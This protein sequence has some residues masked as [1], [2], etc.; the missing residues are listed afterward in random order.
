MKDQ[1]TFSDHTNADAITGAPGS[2]PGA[3]AIGTASGTA[4]GAVIG[5]AGGPIGIAIGAVA[6]GIVGA[7]IGHDIGEWNDPSDYSYWKA[8]YLKR[9]Y[10]DSAADFE[11]DV[12]PAYRYGSNM[13]I[14]HSSSAKPVRSFDSHQDTAEIEW[15]TVRGNSRLSYEQARDA[16]RDA[17]NRKVQPRSKMS[18]N[19]NVSV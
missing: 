10:F 7:V 11:K 16:I 3:T 13:G 18:D 6:G 9:P 19:D 12:A 8:E 1:N 15:V 17:Y 2:H 14:R 4:T 5:M